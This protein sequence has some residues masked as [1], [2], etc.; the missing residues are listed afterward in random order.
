MADFTKGLVTDIFW[1]YY[2][3]DGKLVYMSKNLTKSSLD[4]KISSEDI[5]NGRGNSL[6]ST[7][8]TDREANI[9]LGEN[10][11][12]FDTLSMLS[13]VTKT[14]GAGTGYSDEVELVADAT[15]KITLPVAP[16]AGAIL[17]MQCN[18]VDV[19]GTLS[20]LEVTFATGVTTGDTV[21]VYP[22]EIDTVATTQTITIN[23]NQFP[24]GGVLVLKTKEVSALKKV[25]ADLEIIC[26]NA[27]P[28]GE[29]K[30][31]TTS[32]VQAN[33]QDIAMKICAYND[34]GDMY[35]INRIPRV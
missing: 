4:N 12:N 3:I 25:V 24:A 11:F 27:V 29:W 33:D 5:K 6:F 7:I 15:K 30:L 1:A 18:G 14:I 28:T 26:P 17:N 32:K 31:D 20:T 10:T 23:A 13:G 19:T 9:T 34:N 35:K 2:Y 21:K 22:Y 16:K 8:M